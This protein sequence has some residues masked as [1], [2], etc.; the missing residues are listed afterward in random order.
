MCQDSKR[1][2]AKVYRGQRLHKFLLP[3]VALV[4]TLELILVAVGGH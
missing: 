3:Y 4:V 2:L 1:W